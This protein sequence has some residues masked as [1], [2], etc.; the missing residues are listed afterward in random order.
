MDGLGLGENALHRAAGSGCM[1]SCER[2]L[3]R[4]PRL[5][6]EEDRN[7]ASPLHWAARADMVDAAEILLRHGA[8][9]G[10]AD[11]RGRTALHVAALHGY[12]RMCDLL[13]TAPGSDRVDI[14]RRDH[15]GWAPLHAAAA[16][17]S[18]E[19][20]RAVA[21]VCGS[22]GSRVCVP[23]SAVAAAKTADESRTPLH[24]AALHGHAKAAEFLLEVHQPACFETDVFGQTP[25]DVAVSRGHSNVAAILRGLVETHEQLVRKWCKLLGDDVIEKQL[26]DDVRLSS[27]D[28]A[29]PVLRRVRQDGLLLVCS[30]TDVEYRIIEYILEVRKCGWIQGG[31]AP[32]RIYYARMGKQRKVDTVTFPVPRARPCGIAIWNVGDTCQ[33]RVIARCERCPMLPMAPWQV[34]SDWSEPTHLL[35]RPRD[36]GMAPRR[37]C[38]SAVRLR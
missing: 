9:I 26:P 3:E 16:S 34:V 25:F 32:S 8:D 24:I 17:G 23:R 14:E 33:F 27:L 11:L 38:R 35:L 7:G 19:A 31:A 13:R 20:C 5:N 12:S 30:V 15:C 2:L 1:E 21:W 37:R 18:V 29:P 36:T 10:H 28:V 4:Y 22:D 6:Y